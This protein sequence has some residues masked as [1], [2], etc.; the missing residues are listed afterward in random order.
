[1]PS[2]EPLPL[3]G[4]GWDIVLRRLPSWVMVLVG[5]NGSGSR[6][7]TYIIGPHVVAKPKM[8]KQAKQIIAVA[9]LSVF[10]GLSRSSAKWPTEAKMRKQMNIQTEPAMSDLRRP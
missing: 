9:A 4:S 6:K 3:R 2:I 5:W 8:K 7:K 1:M 10:S